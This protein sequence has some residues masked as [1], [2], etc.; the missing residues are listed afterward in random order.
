M[1]SC[2]AKKS[3][4]YLQRYYAGGPE[5]GSSKGQ[6]VAN[7]SAHYTSLSPS[8]RTKFVQD[9]YQKCGP[10][11]DLEGYVQQELKSTTSTKQAVSIGWLTPGEVADELKLSA[12]FFPTKD[13]FEAAIQKE[14][15]DNQAQHLEADEERKREGSSWWTTRFFYTRTR[16]TESTVVNESIDSM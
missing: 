12:A 10:K 5:A 9:W 14:I 15:D 8:E 16:A 1:P 4:Q 13:D 7:L 11:G 3:F 6:A 2:G